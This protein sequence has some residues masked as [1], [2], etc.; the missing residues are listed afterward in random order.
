MVSVD[1]KYDTYVSGEKNHLWLRKWISVR[2]KKLNSF[3][4]HKFLLT[5]SNNNVFLYW[6]KLSHSQGL[7]IVL[8]DG[9]ILKPLLQTNW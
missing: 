8:I 2:E 7:K 1:N 4:S 6:F 3:L 5:F 9:R